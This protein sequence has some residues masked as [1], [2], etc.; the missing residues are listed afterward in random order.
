LKA[1]N[2]NQQDSD[3]FIFVK[4]NIMETIKCA[5]HNISRVSLVFLDKYN[6]CDENT[7]KN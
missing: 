3:A 1:R 5:V 6:N 7:G 2:R 4:K